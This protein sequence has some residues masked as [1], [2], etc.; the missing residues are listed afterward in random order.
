MT[1]R[2]VCRDRGYSR[3]DVALGWFLVFYCLSFG[4]DEFRVNDR[5]AKV[6]PSFVVSVFVCLRPASHP[7]EH[8]ASQVEQEF[9]IALR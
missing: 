5:D 2:A 6:V 4:D 7:V 8:F 9:S 3:R 1:S